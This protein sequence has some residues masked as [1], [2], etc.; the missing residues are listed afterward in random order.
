MNNFSPETKLN[1]RVN[2]KAVRARARQCDRAPL[3]RASTRR[4]KKY[5]DDLKGWLLYYFPL[6]FFL[7]F[8]TDHDE[9]V[10][11]LEGCIIHGGKHC[12]AMPRGSGKTSVGMG[13]I[14]WSMLEGHRMFP[15]GI[16][17]TGDESRDIINFCKTNLQFNER[18]AEDYP[19]LAAFV[20]E[21]DR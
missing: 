9:L 11:E 14:L 7:D 2:E 19:Q 13:A 18:I 6:I 12:K 5:H 17:A 16:A 8:S 3:S 4:R 21:I 15:V 20:T 10:T 1:Q